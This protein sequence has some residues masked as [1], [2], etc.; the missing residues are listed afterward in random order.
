MPMKP[1]SLNPSPVL[2]APRIITEAERDLARQ[3][4]QRHRD[5]GD[6]PGFDD[7]DE[8]PFDLYMDVLG[9]NG[10]QPRDSTRHRDYLRSRRAAERAAAARDQ[11]SSSESP[12]QAM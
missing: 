4:L 10:R 5:A 1:P 11:S 2:E 9:L 3:W 7:I 8:D 12:H 6:L